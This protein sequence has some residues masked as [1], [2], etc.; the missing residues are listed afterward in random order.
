MVMLIL[1]WTSITTAYPTNLLEEKSSSTTT[2]TEW[3]YIVTMNASLLMCETS[4]ASSTP[5][6]QST[7]P[8]H[9]GICLNGHPRSLFVKQR[10]L[11]QWSKNLLKRY[12]KPKR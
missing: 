4:D 10:L 11:I 5:L 6:I 2:L 3:T 7:W 1:V 12:L 8:V 9:I